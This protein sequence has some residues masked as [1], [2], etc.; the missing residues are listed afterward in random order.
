M[1]TNNKKRH[2][3]RG[4]A[5]MFATAFFLS[6]TSLALPLHAAEP[7]YL[8]VASPLET[9]QQLESATGGGLFDPNQ[10]RPF[11]SRQ[12]A[13]AAPHD[14]EAGDTEQVGSHLFGPW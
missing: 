6:V 2:D 11:Q 7:L 9:A 10:E 3:P 12:A 1:R 4:M 14:L 13:Q 5:M 8:R